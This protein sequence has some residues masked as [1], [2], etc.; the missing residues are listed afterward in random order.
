M[1][2][3]HGFVGGGGQYTI[4]GY[5]VL[6]G[7]QSRHIKGI[8]SQQA[9]MVLPVHYESVV[10]CKRQAYDVGSDMYPSVQMVHDVGE[11]N[12]SRPGCKQR[13]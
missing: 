10:H 13:S 7:K 9:K 1:D 3:P 2:F 8:L 6:D 11:K 4:I 12:A 5:T